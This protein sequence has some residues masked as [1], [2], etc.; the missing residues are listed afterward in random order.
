MTSTCGRRSPPRRRSGAMTIRWMP[1]AASMPT[2]APAVDTT[3]AISTAAPG[4]TETRAP[5]AGYER[6]LSGAF[7]R[8]PSGAYDLEATAEVRTDDLSAP[9]GRGRTG[10]VP[11]Q[12]NR[13]QIGTSDPSG[14][15][16]RPSQGPP[17]RRRGNQ[18]RTGRPAGPARTSATMP[19][20]RNLPA[21]VAAA[22]GVAAV[23]IAAVMW[24]PAGR[25]RADHGHP[26]RRRVRVLRQG[27]REG[28]PPGGGAWPAGRHRRTTGGLLAR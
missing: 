20:G 8:D 4:S 18:P 12:P 22:A 24:R 15:M 26:G 1:A 25:H 5:A 10:E 13:I 11:R 17:P 7:G 23:F 21:A 27:D 28:L 14:S 16:R 2:P 3:V 6:E 19:G 9:I